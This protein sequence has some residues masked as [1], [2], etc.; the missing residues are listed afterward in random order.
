[1]NINLPDWVPLLVILVLI[2]IIIW[3]KF[4]EDI[5]FLMKGEYAEGTIV[6]WMSATEKGTKFFY[7]IIEFS[8]PGGTTISYR[9]EERS[10]GGPMF[11]R[12]TKVRV[13]YLPSNPKR[14]KTIY[15]GN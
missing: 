8:T 10:E 4:L 1:M 7:P 2:A 6:N 12:G 3:W 13:K 5:R 9:A 11:E 15:P 14:V